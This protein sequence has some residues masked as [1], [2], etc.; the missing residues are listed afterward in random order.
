M[1]CITF[2]S[3]RT[4][5]LFDTLAPQ[6][7]ADYLSGLLIGEEIREALEL[8]GVAKPTRVTLLCKPELLE[9]YQ[10]ALSSFAIEGIGG[11]PHASF[12][13]MLAIARACDLI[14]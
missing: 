1:R 13:G 11:P 7:R 5:A 10:A 6:L 8:I 12:R 9:R 14:D 4:R 3:V 2:F